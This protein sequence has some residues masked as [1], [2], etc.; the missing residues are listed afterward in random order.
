MGIPW[1]VSSN[2]T[3]TSSNNQANN[4]NSTP[5]LQARS[6]DTSTEEK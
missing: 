1:T 5:A 6:S 2:T 3:T 4:S